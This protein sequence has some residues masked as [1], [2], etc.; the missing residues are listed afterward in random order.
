MLVI[1]EQNAYAKLF[2]KYDFRV[3]YNTINIKISFNIK[4]KKKG[5]KFFFGTLRLHLGKIE[6]PQINGRIIE[7]KETKKT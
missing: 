7:T 5:L 4:F 6:K 1:A 3:V 2:K